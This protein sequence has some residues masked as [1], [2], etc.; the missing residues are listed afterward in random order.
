MFY[1]S[2][3]HHSGGNLDYLCIMAPGESTKPSE[4][5]LSADDTPTARYNRAIFRTLKNELAKNPE[6]DIGAALPKYYSDKLEYLQ[7]SGMS[8]FSPSSADD[9]D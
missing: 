1:L 6:I 8:F 5:G 4:G 7:Q 9:F 2:P 3:Q